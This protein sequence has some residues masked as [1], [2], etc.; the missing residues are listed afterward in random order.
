MRWTNGATWPHTGHDNI[1]IAI[2]VELRI[3]HLQSPFDGLI[4][5]DEILRGDLAREQKHSTVS[6]W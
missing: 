1:L 2:Q 6:V 3:L 4:N 5:L